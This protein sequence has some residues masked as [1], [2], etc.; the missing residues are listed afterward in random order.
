MI[1][2]LYWGTLVFSGITAFSRKIQTNKRLNQL[3]IMITVVCIVL[4]A[5]ANRE[6]NDIIN[7]VRDYNSV[8]TFQREPIYVVLKILGKSIGLNF[9]QFRAVVS[10]IGYMLIVSTIKKYTSNVQFV[11]FFYCT[12]LLFM[13][14][15]QVR[16]FLAVS[17]F[18]YS[19]R[20]LSNTGSKKN[21]IAYC[22]C[23][24]I[25]T[26]IHTAFI[27]YYILTLLYIKKRR[28]LVYSL[29]FVMAALSLITWLNDNKIPFIDI[30]VGILMGDNARAQEYFSLTTNLG[31][32]APV[33]LYIYGILGVFLV[34][35]Q[36]K[37]S[38]MDNEK[39]K[40]CDLVLLIN[41]CFISTIPMSMM[42]LTFYRLIRNLQYLNFCV[43]ANGYCEQNK[44]RKR[45][46]IIMFVVLLCMGW[47]VFD[48]T[49]Y[50]SAEYIVTPVFEGDW[51]WK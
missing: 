25:S 11:L 9:Y 34:K 24:L 2:S 36:T 19:V 22:V 44:L 17:V 32:L 20:F 15:W 16:N 1:E 50:S 7:Y 6:G 5:S 3:C 40:F 39:I 46:V 37:T 10:L 18:V 51:F 35:R 33:A 12:Y 13:D 23:I 48:F 47:L 4:I 31:F 43:Y 26:G 29:C 49:M 21:L 27:I 28:V 38:R 14:S 42:S 41:L 45:L 30:V 8:Q